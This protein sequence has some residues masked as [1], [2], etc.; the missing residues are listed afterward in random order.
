MR[1]ICP[2]TVMQGPYGSKT[3]VHCEAFVVTS[4][5]IWS[6]LNTAAISVAPIH[7]LVL[8]SLHPSCSEPGLSNPKHKETEVTVSF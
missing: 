6:D 1:V 7:F 8:I 3:V 2:G 4:Y 5:L